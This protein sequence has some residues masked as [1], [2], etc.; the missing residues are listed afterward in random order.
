MRFN[1]TCSECLNILLCIKIYRAIRKQNN[2]VII[3]KKLKFEI[4]IF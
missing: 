1:A 4:Y 2:I 3:L